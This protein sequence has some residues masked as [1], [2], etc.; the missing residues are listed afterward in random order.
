MLASVV[1]K[2]SGWLGGT[3]IECATVHVQNGLLAWLCLRACPGLRRAALEN[4]ETRDLCWLDACNLCDSSELA[5]EEVIWERRNPD[6]LGVHELA[7]WNLSCQMVSQLAS[8]GDS[9]REEFLQGA[10]NHGALERPCW[11]RPVRGHDEANGP[12]RSLDEDKGRGEVE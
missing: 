6:E 12:E 3:H 1:A 7:I 9:H 2:C 5:R 11:T 8:G 4:P 10:Y